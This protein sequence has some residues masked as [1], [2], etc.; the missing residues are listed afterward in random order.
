MD[1]TGVVGK[2]QVTKAVRKVRPERVTPSLQRPL[3]YN[4][5]LRLAGCPLWQWQALKS[6]FVFEDRGNVFVKGK[7]KMYTYFLVGP[8]PDVTLTVEGS[9][10][11]HS[12]DPSTAALAAGDSTIADEK[13]P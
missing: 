6:H 9:T 12:T 3:A 13:E 2:V 10:D 7:G 8:Q 5:R 1:Y 4:R 11:L